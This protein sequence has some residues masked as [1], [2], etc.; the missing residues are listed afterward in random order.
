MNQYFCQ[1]RG[2][3]DSAKFHCNCGGTVSLLCANHTNYHLESPGSHALNRIHL[4]L[5]D[6]QRQEIDIALRSLPLV[7][8]KATAEASKD[9]R[10]A[11]QTLLRQLDDI[12]KAHLKC[13][14][15]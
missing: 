14:K 5:T 8:G 2:C 3:C 7:C 6:K 9:L 1:V 15:Y 10:Q 12:Q 4:V 11:S 13:Q